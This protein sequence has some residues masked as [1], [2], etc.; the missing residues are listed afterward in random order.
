MAKLERAGEVAG[1]ALK[2]AL[3]M[4]A[5]VVL[6]L[7]GLYALR[8]I[9]GDDLGRADKSPSVEASKPEPSRAAIEREEY[10]IPPPT[11]P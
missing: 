2:W 6:C 8:A 1:E 10:E 4:V 7:V 11:Y 9:G 3:A 5:L